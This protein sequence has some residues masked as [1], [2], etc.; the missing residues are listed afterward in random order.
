MVL[1]TKYHRGCIGLVIPE[2]KEAFY[3]HG[4]R[5]LASKSCR[6]GFAAA[7]NVKDAVP[8]TARRPRPPF[9][10]SELSF[11]RRR[12]LVGP[13]HLHSARSFVGLHCRRSRRSRERSALPTEKV[14]SSPFFFF[15]FS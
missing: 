10:H 1:A 13:P 11:R 12:F 4:Q 7:A 14:H 8:A 15:F 6:G 3:S 2:L 5:T 9:K